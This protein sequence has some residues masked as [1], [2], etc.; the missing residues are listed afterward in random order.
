MGSLNTSMENGTNATTTAAGELSVNGS[1]LTGELAGTAFLQRRLKVIMLGAGISGIQFAH[2]VDTRMENVEL[3]IYEK[4]PE[5]G[6]TWYENRYPGCACDVPAHTY[7]FSWAPNT[8]WS[9]FYAPAPEI[10]QYLNDVVDNHGLRKYM[11]FN[12]RAVSA[13]WQEESS[14]WRVELETTDSSGKAVTIVRECDVLVKGL[15]SLNNWKYPNIEGLSK[16]KGK[17]MHTANWDAT[18]DLT[19]KRIAVIGN[20]ASAVQCVAALQPGNVLQL[21]CIMLQLNY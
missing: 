11:K 6:G 14:T 3:D 21:S 1:R 2:D 18:V 16:F 17:L 13:H 12:H 8:R 10:L 9:K 7:H 4:N 15:G 20:G 5:L 19:G